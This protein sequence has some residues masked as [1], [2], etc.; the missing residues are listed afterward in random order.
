MGE[1]ESPAALMDSHLS[2]TSPLLG[3]GEG[4]RRRGEAA[5]QPPT[6]F[7][8]IRPGAAQVQLL[9][10]QPAQRPQGHTL[11]EGDGDR[12]PS[13]RWRLPE[14]SSFDGVGSP[15][16]DSAGGAAD[17]RRPGLH[18]QLDSLPEDVVKDRKQSGKVSRKPARCQGG[19]A[20]RRRGT[21]CVADVVGSGR[22]ITRRQ[23]RWWW[24]AKQMHRDVPAINPAVASP[25]P[26]PPPDMQRSSAAQ[27]PARTQTGQVSSGELLLLL[28]LL[29][30]SSELTHGELSSCW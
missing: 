27:Q 14:G 3:G 22:L 7:P 21:T 20:V 4:Q 28:L 16:D 26:A 19:K 18:G 11:Q 2:T 17:A 8:R 25:A 24:P 15:Q 5:Q 1:L 9:L 13:P 29:L 23:G 6:G 12:A 10:R 30:F